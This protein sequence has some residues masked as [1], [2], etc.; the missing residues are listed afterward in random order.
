MCRSPSPSRPNSFGRDIDGE[1]PLDS[2]WNMV[3]LFQ[4]LDHV[5]FETSWCNIL[6]I[7]SQLG[8]KNQTHTPGIKLV[9]CKKNN[10]IIL[11]GGYWWLVVLVVP[12]GKSGERGQCFRFPFWGRYQYFY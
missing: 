9:A 5:L 7:S 10:P 3:G 6:S 4:M 12:G 1:K 11:G 2:Y 8:L